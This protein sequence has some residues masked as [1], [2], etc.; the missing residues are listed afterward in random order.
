MLKK[1]S[2]KQVAEFGV[3]IRF[4]LIVDRLQHALFH[5]I[6]ISDVVSHKAQCLV[7]GV[8]AHRFIRVMVA[9]EHQFMAS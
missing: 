9:R 1:C 7:H 6:Q 3:Y 8:F 2:S 4:S 5:S